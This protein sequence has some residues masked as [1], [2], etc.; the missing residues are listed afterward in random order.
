MM[1]IL[2]WI[3]WY[4]CIY[5]SNAGFASEG[6]EKEVSLQV[7]QALSAAV[8]LDRFP[9]SQLDIVILVLQHDGGMIIIHHPSFITF[10]TFII[11]PFITPFIIVIVSFVFIDLLILLALISCAECCYYMC[12]HG[13]G[14]CWN[15]DVWFGTCL[16]CCM[17]LLLHSFMRTRLTW[18]CFCY[19]VSGSNTWK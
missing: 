10:I 14:R 9:K 16:H 3:Q 12:E 8:R 4:L 5:I 11:I 18:D 17:Y 2:Y 19:R 6:E 7:Q 13:F 1:M 15:W